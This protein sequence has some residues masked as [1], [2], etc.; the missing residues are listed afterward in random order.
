MYLAKV[1]FVVGAVEC[2]NEY[3][4]GVKVW[5]DGFD[6]VKELSFVDG[7]G[8]VFVVWYIL[9]ALKGGGYFGVSSVGL[10]DFGVVSGVNDGSYE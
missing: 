4:C 2:G 10:N 7:D 3:E 6:I 8:I 5:Y 9:E 1:L